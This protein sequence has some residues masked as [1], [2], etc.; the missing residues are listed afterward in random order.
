MSE[1]ARPLEHGSGHGILPFPWRLVRHQ[2]CDG[3]HVIGTGQDGPGPRVVD[4]PDRDQRHLARPGSRCEALELAEADHRLARLLAFRAED[5]P[6]R[7]IVWAIEQG[8]IELGLGMRG[9]AHA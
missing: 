9:D 7:Q 1:G 8:A 2:R 4:A 3:G 5:R 6:K